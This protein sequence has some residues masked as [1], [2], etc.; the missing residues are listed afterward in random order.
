MKFFIT[1]FL[2]V[3]LV[4]A[5][6]IRSNSAEWEMLNKIK[7]ENVVSPTDIDLDNITSETWK[8][9]RELCPS[10]P[11]SPRINVYFDYALENTTTL[12]Y[13]SQN[14]HLTSSGFWVSTIYEAMTQR[15]NSSL[16]IA[17]DMHIAF[18]PYPPNGW[19]IEKNCLNISARFSLRTVLRH[20]LLHGLI[21]AGSLREVSDTF[22][23]V[24]TIGY[25]F[26]GKCFPRLYDTKIKYDDGSSIFQT[27]P[28]NTIPE[29]QECLLRVDRSV[30]GADLYIGGVQLYH[31]YSYRSGSSISH[32]NYPGH[33]MY[34]STTPMVCYDLGSYEGKI[35]AAMGIECTINNITYEAK[36]EM[37]SVG[38]VLYIFVFITLIL[39]C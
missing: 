12:A 25:T 4:E 11:T 9:I 34:A 24:W 29:Y 36:G 23:L 16:G 7:V 30:V 14:L 18:N 32:H 26:G 35:L 28:N 20:E 1:L 3:G 27:L 5:H 38:R 17:F 33:L 19:Y 37:R 13:A 22:G 6:V 39:L 10:L 31:P 21:F 2:V 15:R 8:E